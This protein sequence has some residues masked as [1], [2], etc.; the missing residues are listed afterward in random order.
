MACRRLSPSRC[1]MNSSDW[2]T[3]LEGAVA[4][5]QAPRIGAERR[6]HSA[7]AV[8]RK[9]APLHGAPAG[10]HARLGMQVA[11]DLAGRAGRLVPER[12]RADR[13]FL[14]DHPAE[15]AWQ[16]RIVIA[17]NPDPVAPRLQGAR[18]L[19]G[20]CPTG[21]HPL[22]GRERIPERDH[23]ARV[24]ARNHGG[25]AAQR[26]RGVVRRQQNAARGKARAFFQMQIRTTSRL[27]SSQNSA[28]EISG[29]E[30]DACDL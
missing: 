13:N 10:R 30:R 2:K 23:H 19:R 25:E 22:R 3:L 12:D 20:R 27:C 1:A 14:R 15:I 8:S 7:F 11:R 9:A 6:H 4:D 16:R 5:A 29:C 18:A 24:V 21:A 17:R 28:P 26:R